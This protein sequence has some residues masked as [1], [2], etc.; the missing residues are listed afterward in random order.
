MISKDA[1]ITIR[2][3]PLEQIH[4]HECQERYEEKLNLYMHLLRAHPG[5]YAGI[6]FLAPCS[7]HGGFYV[8]D[9]HHKFVAS[10]MTGRRDMLS[11]I[12]EEDE[13]L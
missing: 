6:A 5:Q 7:Q 2:R 4:V 1:R 8:Q 3:V 12:I 10:I 11:A 13:S 9:G